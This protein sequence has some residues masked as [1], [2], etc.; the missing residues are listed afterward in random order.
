M[1][2]SRTGLAS[3]GSVFLRLALGLSFLSAVADRFGLWGAFGQP[4]VAWGSFARFVAYTARLNW[5]LPPAVIPALAS[6]A[7]GAETLLGL[8]LLVGWYTR[9][10]ALLSGILLV[11]FGITMTLAL[12]VEA[13]LNFS[14]FS[15]AGGAFVLATCARYP[16]SVDELL[17][18][19]R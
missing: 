19:S 16:F 8:C 3:F 11:L 6:L 7:T 14:V 18:R 13:P 4:N 17:L 12:G 1:T 5:F 9:T 10:T 2:P 15:A